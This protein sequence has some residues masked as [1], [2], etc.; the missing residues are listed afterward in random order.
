MINGMLAQRVAI[1]TGANRNI[2]AAIALRLARDGAATAINYPDPSAADEAESVVRSIRAAGGR[3][4]AVQ[5]DVSDPD[6]VT[7]MAETVGDLF[8]P[9]DILVNNAAIEVTSQAP[10]HELSP[11]G[12]ARVF[13]IN[14]TG[15][16]LCARAL[17][18]GMRAKGRGDIVSLSSITAL[19]GRTGNLH[20]VT[21][22]SALIGFTRALAREVG[23]EGIRVNSLIVG[24][25]QTPQELAYGDP[26]AVSAE[27]SA[28]QSLNRRGLPAD[29]AGAVAFLVSEDAGFITGQSLVVD[30]GWAMQ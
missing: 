6:E 23:K 30:G 13:A 22:K 19:L 15:G 24:A 2:G 18:K 11:E 1:I 4:S 25:I 17:H 21:S 7:R 28:L 27:L 14:V 20:Y 5:A 8:G 26:D 12:W 3:A 10:W 29:V 16:F 9:A